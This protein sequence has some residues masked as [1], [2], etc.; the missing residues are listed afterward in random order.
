[1][2]HESTLDQI[3]SE[4]RR[5]GANSIQVSRDANFEPDAG[6]LIHISLGDADWRLLPQELEQL[7]KEIPAGAGEEGVRRAIETKG[8]AVWHGPAP[9][10]S[11]DSSHQPS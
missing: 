1:M 9:K 5:I 2:A 8:S 3:R 11:R 10:D 7:L 6:E 4:L